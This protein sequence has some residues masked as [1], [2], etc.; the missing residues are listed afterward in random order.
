MGCPVFCGANFDANRGSI[1]DGNQ[2]LVGLTL[3]QVTSCCTFEIWQARGHMFVRLP[4][5]YVGR[6][7]LTAY[8]WSS[9][10]RRRFVIVKSVAI[11]L[12]HPTRR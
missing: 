8:R 3:L 10:A 12:Y 7:T 11:A 5:G 4:E 6:R 1:L 9:R 2:Q